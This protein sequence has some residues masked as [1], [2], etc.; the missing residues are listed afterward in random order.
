MLLSKK[1]I[2][3]LLFLSSSLSLGQGFSPIITCP[4]PYAC[5]LSTYLGLQYPDGTHQTTAYTGGGGSGSVTSVAFAD[6]STIPLY[7]ISGSPITTAGTITATLSTQTANK[8][9]S[10][11]TTGSAA[12]PTFRSLV[13]ADL[14]TGALSDVGT[15]GITVGNGTG[16]VIGSGTTIS[17]H[18]SDTT[19]SGYL[20]SSDWNTFNGK[21][22]SGN[23][24]TALT[25]DVSASGPGSAAATVNSV[26]GSSASNVNAATV[27]AN[28][29]TSANTASAICRRDS[30][31]NFSAGTIT[32][33]I[34]GTASGNTT[35]TPNQYGV[36]LSG[37]SN[38]MSVLAPDASTT[39]VLKSG[40][41]SANPSWLAY[42][43]ANT[44]ST[45]VARDGSGNFSAG[46]I[47]AALTGTAS[48]NPPNARTISTT[49][50]ITGGGDL[51]AD[52]TFAIPAATNSVNGYLTSA[53]WTTFNG[54]QASGNYVTAL[55]G[56]VTASGPGSVASTV[57]LVGGSSAADVHTSQLATVAATDAN[58]ASTIVK[59][60]AS[61]NFSFG[62]GTGAIT[63]TA[64]GNTTY[65][66]NQYGVILSGSGNA[67]SVLAPDASASKL[68]KSG[69]ASANP[70]WL[71]YTDA[72]TALTVVARDGSGNFSAGTIS[73]ALTGTA[74]GNTTYSAN[75]YGVVLSGS[76]NTMS[77]LAPDA[78]TSKVLKSEGASANPSWL[79]YTDANTASTL[80]AR[81]ASGNFSAGTITAALTGT[82]SG[83]LVS[84]GA[85]GTPSSGTMTNVS[86]T[87]AS[88]TAGAATLAISTSALKSATT[89]VNVD[90]ATAP[91]AN[92][93]L[94]ATD[95]THATWVTPSG[96]GTVTSV[97][98]TVPAFLSI[99][100]SPVTTSGTLAIS[101]SGTAL[102]I[103][104]GGTAVTAAPTT[105]SAS[106]FAAWDASVNLPANNHYNA[107]TTTAQA[108]GTTTLTVASTKQQ[109]FTGSA[110]QTIVLPVVS[111]L[112]SL[113]FSFEIVNLGTGTLTVQSS[114]GNQI[115]QTLRTLGTR[116]TY[117]AILLTGTTA[118]SWNGS[119]YTVIVNGGVTASHVPT[120]TDGSGYQLSDS[121][122]YVNNNPTSGTPLAGSVAVYNGQSLLN[123]QNMLQNYTT[124]ATAAGTTTLTINS[125]QLQVFTGSSNQT[126]KLPST[127]ASATS[128][129]LYYE[130]WNT[131]TGV[132]SIQTSTAAALQTMAP[133]TWAKFQ[134]NSITDNTAAR[135]NIFY[136]NANK[137][138]LTQISR[139]RSAATALTTATTV[140]VAQTTTKLTLTAG[141]WVIYGTCGF[142]A[143]ATTTI[144]NL[145]CAV[146]KTSA[147]LPATDTTSV[148]T[149]G[150][151]TAIESPAS[152]VLN[153]DQTLE[154][155]PVQVSLTAS[156]DYY[157]VGQGT[158]GVST[159]SVY[160]SMY[161]V[162][163]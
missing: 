27:L 11:P 25:S 16:A 125:T 132:L 8:V 115:G 29:A 119:N 143:G 35:Y 111:T 118:A 100:G 45:L 32:A 150:E 146:S 62:T 3:L 57:A 44:A 117:T 110:G 79:A 154:M 43:D 2:G 50:P 121:S 139:L 87:A 142:T 116:Q 157:L 89:T 7:S 23:Y 144:S 63:G 17:Q 1:I 135:W 127:G 113:G 140:N 60:D 9:F 6:G 85:L 82:A 19:H 162:P 86:G 20:S 97:A 134:V 109:F 47:T 38:A 95:S 145:T 106:N 81:D 155:R 71:A 10:G 41:A 128:T 108:G 72:N 98:Q 147:T 91:T 77:V 14:P 39:K 151:Y 49:S 137:T 58:T 156:T 61:G 138:S 66:A 101:Y 48:G 103:A 74:S 59:R 42:T 56:D 114:G 75:Q 13:A 93:V 148:P 70:S 69:G 22:A 83:N 158:F 152:A 64:S 18:V 68:L 28:A 54:K 105:A 104:N 4:G 52:R 73:A 129:G 40:G 67:M 153:G 55:T 88:L 53:D 76:G 130:I 99:A 102:P 36:V 136:S 26:G 33:S 94:T 92:Q 120:F 90:A 107:Y 37:A 122:Y 12:Q 163:Q 160:G 126:V 21:Q 34:T 15:D 133:N 112:P 30:S 78:S 96:S 141:D 65:T 46:T 24:L 123:V 131:S 149:A 5:I 124:T 161:A 31:G 159:L 84:G 51:S 80:V